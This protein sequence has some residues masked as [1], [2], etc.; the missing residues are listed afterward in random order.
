ML[1]AFLVS[2]QMA[3]LFVYPKGSCEVFKLEWKYNNEQKI[4]FNLVE[5]KRKPNVKIPFKI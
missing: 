2:K 3:V 1:N 4:L 5:F